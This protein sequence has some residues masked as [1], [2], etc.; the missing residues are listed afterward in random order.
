VIANQPHYLGGVL[1]SESAAKGAR[2]VR[3][4]NAF[5][6]P[7]VVLVDTPGSCPAPS[8]SRAA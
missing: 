6:L 3:T 1:D 7:L 2:F 4:C 8:R 5:G